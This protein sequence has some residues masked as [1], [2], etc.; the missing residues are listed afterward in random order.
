MAQLFPRW[1]NTAVRAALVG[2]GALLVVVPLGVLAFARTPVATGQFAAVRQPVRF[3]HP[4]HV[5][6]LRIDCRYCHAGAERGPMAGLPPT[7]ACVPCHDERWLNS[8][9]FAAVRRSLAT[10]RPIP[11][12]RVTALPDFVFFNHAAHV[13]KGVGCETCH[14]R[15]DLMQEVY[16]TAPLT[17]GWCLDCHRA[18][19]RFLRPVEQVTAMG[20]TADG[21]PLAEGRALA[22][23]YHV[24]RLTTCTACHR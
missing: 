3:S 2:A 16:Q 10:R 20:W 22:A 17:M 9:L 12:R 21:Q 6:G 5:N 18:P 13:R 8:S 24:R 15:V 23:R 19:A 11:W 7:S 14:G 4:L 1:A